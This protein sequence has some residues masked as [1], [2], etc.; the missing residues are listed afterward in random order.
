MLIRN[1]LTANMSPLV[2]LGGGFMSQ[3]HD[4][5]ITLPSVSGFGRLAAMPWGHTHPYAIAM[6]ITAGGMASFRGIAGAGSFTGSIAGGKNGTATLSGSGTLAA[7]G[8]LI[9]SMQA[10]L[11]GS[12][13]ISGAE[14]R[15]FLNLAAALSGSGG[16]TA[17]LNAIGHLATTLAGQGAATATLTAL[18]TLA[19]SITVTGA[20]LTTANVASAIL[21]AAGGVETNVTMRQALRLIVAALAGKLSGA[22]TTTITIRNAVEDD[23][24]RIIATVDSNGNRSAIT[25]DLD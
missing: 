5:A 17:Q 1:G 18:G 23:T 2:L 13:T 21:D 11:A 15:A 14:L 8:Q 10:A 16:L 9:V 22:S 12:G 7:V 3:T 25:Y 19:S 6:P 24:S 4:T 20:T